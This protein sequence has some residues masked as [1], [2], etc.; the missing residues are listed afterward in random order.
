MLQYNV[1]YKNSQKSKMPYLSP[2]PFQ[3]S[4]V[5]H[6]VCVCVCSNTNNYYNTG[7]YLINICTYILDNIMMITTDHGEECHAFNAVLVNKKPRGWQQRLPE[8]CSENTVNSVRFFLKV[9]SIE[10]YLNSTRIEYR[11]N[12][13]HI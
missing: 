5:C 1:D 8:N 11:Y 10:M 2:S 7:K 13:R 6:W 4:W 3:N 12:G 9:K